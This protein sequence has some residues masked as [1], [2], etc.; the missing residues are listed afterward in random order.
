MYLR[1]RVTVT[2][3]SA[4]KWQVREAQNGRNPWVGGSCAPLGSKGVTVGR[5]LCA[6]L[7]RVYEEKDQTIG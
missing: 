4:V 7:F 1:L 5:D 6:E 3:G 2:A